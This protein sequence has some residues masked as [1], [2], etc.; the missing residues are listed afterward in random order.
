MQITGIIR[1]CHRA[2]TLLFIKKG[3]IYS[4]LCIF[5]VKHRRTVFVMI[6]HIAVMCFM[7]RLPSALTRG[8]CT[9]I[10]ILTW[11]IFCFIKE[12][13]Y[14]KLPSRRFCLDVFLGIMNPIFYYDF[15][16]HQKLLRVS[17]LFYIVVLYG[18]AI[19]CRFIEKRNLFLSEITF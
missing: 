18:T 3:T 5:I 9:R 6:S 14:S 17:Y 10:T 8:I 13:R 19:F 12:R 4:I 1:N 7:D 15:I 16:T 2:P 11:I